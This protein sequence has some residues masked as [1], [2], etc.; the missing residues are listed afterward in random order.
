MKKV[1][2]IVVL[3]I[4]LGSQSIYCEELTILTENLPPLNYVVLYKA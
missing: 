1:F 3:V 2:F 4:I